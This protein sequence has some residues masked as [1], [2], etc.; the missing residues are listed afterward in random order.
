MTQS[1]K[2]PPT[3]A[4]LMAKL[5]YLTGVVEPLVPQ[6]SELMQDKR[7]KVISDQ[8]VAKF[9]KDNPTPP[10]SQPLPPSSGNDRAMNAKLI[11]ALGI[12]LAVILALVG[13]ITQLPKLAK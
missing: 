6:V 9:V 1:Y 4:E 8:A 10:P 7:D 13:L 3:N 5:D 2:K 12:A 11:T